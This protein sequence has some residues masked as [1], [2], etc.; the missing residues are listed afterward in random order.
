MRSLRL[1]I[2]FGGAAVI[3]GAALL[4]DPR[5]RGALDE[6][7]REAVNAIIESARNEGLPTEPLV[8][9]ALEG[10]TKRATGPLII[11]AVRNWA[12]ELRRAR[13]ALGPS[14]SDR[15]VEAGATALRAGV[16]VGELERLRVSKAGPGRL[17]SS[18]DVLTFLVRAGVPADTIAP[19]IV[20]LVL[21]A[22]TEDQ[23]ATFQRDV[24]RDI[25]HGVAAATAASL[26]GQGLERQLAS[27]SNSGGPGSTL[28]SVRGQ[29]RAVDPL[30]NPQAVGTQGTANV[31]GAG[32]GARPA[33]PRGKPKPKP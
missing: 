10:A 28:P 24:E 11:N 27:S 32:E 14:V 9:K 20:R 26:R 15:D 25:A 8:D 22:A 4:D 12:S 7:T 19:V 30:V 2:I 3:S 17:A 29:Q 23:L 5:L 31:S 1:A 18:L 6:R 13:S 33:G 21:A 16:S